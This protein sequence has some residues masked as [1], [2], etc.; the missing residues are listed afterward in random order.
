MARKAGYLENGNHTFSKMQSFECRVV[1]SWGFGDYSGIW[2]WHALWD[3]KWK[4]H[5]AVLNSLSMV[6]WY[7]LEPRRPD[8]VVG[9]IVLCEA[10][11]ATW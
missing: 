4:L 1:G 2:N 6:Q 3:W 9:N 5:S 7:L 11:R 8:W 10:R